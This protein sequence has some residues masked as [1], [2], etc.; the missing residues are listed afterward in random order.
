LRWQLALDANERALNAASGTLT[1]SELA[2]WRSE[3]TDERK[4]TATALARLA[5][6]ARVRPAPWLP[7]MA[8]TAPML[9][10]PETVE[11]CLFDLDGVLTDSGVLHA[12]AWAAVFDEFLQRV[13]ERNRWHFIPFDREADYLTYI[14]GRPRLEGIHAFLDSRGI[15]LPEGRPD[16][17][18]DAETAYG[19][20]RRKGD[21]LARSLHG[22]G[23]TALPGA[24]RYLEATGYAG[25][26]RAIVS[27]S[28]N[29]LPM[30]ELA[31]LATLVEDLADANLIRVEKLRSRPAPDLLLAASRRLGVDPANVATF[32]PT[33]AGI[34]AGHAAGLIVVGMGDGPRGELLRGFGAEQVVPSLNALLDRRLR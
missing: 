9:G 34:V 21:G 14:D 27:A 29:T 22:R 32:T 4:E 28:A 6:T 17:P 5:R 23:V 3:H 8:I 10:L 1:D 30:L 7:P 19:L 15:R 2:R 20:A 11:A 26:K 25:L 18:P 16:D 12:W 13:A 24:R 33:P 31:G